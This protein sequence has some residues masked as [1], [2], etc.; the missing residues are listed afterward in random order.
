MGKRR[1]LDTANALSKIVLLETEA[2]FRFK[3][4]RCNLPK[5]AVSRAQWT[6]TEGD[7]TICMSCYEAIT[8]KRRKIQKKQKQKQT[9]NEETETEPIVSENS[10]SSSSGEQAHQVVVD[11][12]GDVEGEVYRHEHLTKLDDYQSKLKPFVLGKEKITKT[13]Y[14]RFVDEFIVLLSG[15]REVVIKRE[16][17]PADFDAVL[18][19]QEK[20]EEEEQDIKPK[21]VIKPNVSVE[22]SFQF[23][24]TFERLLTLGGIVMPIVSKNVID[25]E[26]VLK[27]CDAIISKRDAFTDAQQSFFEKTKKRTKFEIEKQKESQQWIHLTTPSELGKPKSVMIDSFHNFTTVI[28][29]LKTILKTDDIYRELISNASAKGSFFGSLVLITKGLK[30][31]EKELDL[32]QLS[33]IKELLDIATKKEDLLTKAQKQKVM[34]VKDQL[35]LS[36]ANYL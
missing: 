22:T 11:E 8:K 32:T 6:T 27:L 28:Q 18:F 29:T 36:I 1:Y 23:Y 24:Q 30:E 21:I 26:A 2:P 34:G 12:R 9:T 17:P 33:E 35:L 7:K 10:N 3:C 15:E 25:P 20:T 13:I 14:E 31:F 4:F 5:K 16:E 19:K